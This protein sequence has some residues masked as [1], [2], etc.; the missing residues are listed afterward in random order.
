MSNSV[1]G[2]YE[3]VEVGTFRVGNR[4]FDIR[5]KQ[6]EEQGLEQID[7]LTV[8][9]LDSSPRNI[10]VLAD[11]QEDV[12]SVCI[13]RYDRERSI[14][15]YANTAPDV[16]LSEVVNVMRSTTQS[17]LPPGYGMRFV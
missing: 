2:T 7:L 5:L 3:G 11:V 17:V 9:S 16:S 6:K 4:S 13:N 14:W 1:R 10:R 8:G 12:R 15:I